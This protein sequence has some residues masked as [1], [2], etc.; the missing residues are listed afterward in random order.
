MNT[1]NKDATIQALRAALNA[2]LTYFGMDE[3]EWSKPV[4]DQARAALKTEKT[5]S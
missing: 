2:M 4:F 3:D 5:T 1:D